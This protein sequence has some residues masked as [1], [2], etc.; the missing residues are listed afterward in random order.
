MGQNTGTTKR[1]FLLS[2]AHTGGK[3]AELILN[4]QAQFPLARQLH[5][6]RTVGLGELFSFLSALYFRG[7]LTYARKFAVPPRG[8]SGAL[9]I[10]PGRGLMDAESLI[11]LKDLLSFSEVPVDC[12]DVRYRAP[13]EQHARRLA[14]RSGCEFVLLGSVSTQKYAAVL[15]PHLGERLLFP[16]DFVSRGDMSRGGL[17]LRSARAGR[18]LEYIP[19][20]GAVLRGPRPA[21]LEKLTSG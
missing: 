21:K 11:S 18:E 6:G 12:A 10:T 17:L 15:L 9:V 19:L 3:R 5:R 16:K 7:K 1:I 4:R 8:I 2:P 14:A 20:A 13:M